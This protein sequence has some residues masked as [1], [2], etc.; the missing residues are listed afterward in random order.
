M[1]EQNVDN[2]SYSDKPRTF[3]Q[4][5]ANSNRC[6]NLVA[7]MIRGI[8]HDP[9]FVAD[10]N[11]KYRQPTSAICMAK[12][13][14]QQRQCRSRVRVGTRATRPFIVGQQLRRTK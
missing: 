5:L 11:K 3:A 10:A 1:T 4:N 6:T 13:V 14:S 7:K 2:N 8:S 9:S 12:L